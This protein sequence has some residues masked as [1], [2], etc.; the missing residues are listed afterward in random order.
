MLRVQSFIPVAIPLP[1][2]RHAKIEEELQT[3]VRANRERGAMR[4]SSPSW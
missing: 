2:V 4:D 3:D 1:R